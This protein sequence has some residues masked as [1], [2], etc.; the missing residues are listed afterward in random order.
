MSTLF[1]QG[2]NEPVPQDEREVSSTVT[3]VDGDAEPAVQE[4]VTDF[5][6]TF[7]DPDTE[8]GLTPHQVASFVSPS[9]RYVPNVDASAQDEHNAMINRQVSTAGVA[10]AKEATGEWGHGTMKLVEGIEPTIRDGSQLG[11]DYFTAYPHDVG[12]ASGDYMTPAQPADPTT[13]GDAAATAVVAARKATQS[14]YYQQFLSNQ[15]GN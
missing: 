1:Y 12:K 8:G 4:H 5:N 11:S 14:S 15:T 7:T 13:R 9:V 10:P 6:E 3:V 2:P